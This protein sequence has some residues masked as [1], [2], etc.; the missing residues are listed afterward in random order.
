MQYFSQDRFLSHIKADSKEAVLTLLC[1]TAAASMEVPAD[2]F[3]HVMRREALGSTSFGNYVAIPHPDRP[4]GQESFVV[5][6][7][8]E[9]PILWDGDE[10]QIVFLIFMKA[11]G[12]R[13]LQL[14]YRSVS[15][16]LSDKALVQRLLQNQT[17]EE[18]IAI[19]ESLSYEL[20]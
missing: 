1:Q 2:A 13:N 16:F 8:L 14:F 11:G 6:G 17:Y 18:L 7:I 12:D 20:R 19:L 3:D 5:T 4:M 9:R 15:R 10:V